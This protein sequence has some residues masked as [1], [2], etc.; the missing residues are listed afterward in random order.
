MRKFAL[1]LLALLSFVFLTCGSGNY[2]S[3][4][5]VYG[6]EDTEYILYNYHPELYRYYSA[7]VLRVNSIRQVVRY[8]GTVDYRVNYD[9]VRYYY[10]DAE[11]INAVMTYLPD[12]YVKY[13]NGQI[14][15]NYVWRYVESGNICHAASYRYYFN[16]YY[17]VYYPRVHKYYYMMPLPPPRHIGPVHHHNHNHYSPGYNH[18]PG[19]PKPGGMGPGGNHHNDHRP[20]GPG[21]HGGG[22]KPGG[23]NGSVRPGPG[24]G[25]GGGYNPPRSSGGS[26]GSRVGGTSPAHHGSPSTARP[27]TSSPSR[28]S[29]YGGGYRSGQPTHHS[30]PSSSPSRSSYGGSSHSGSHGRSQSRAGGRR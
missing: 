4:A 10:S 18:H 11:K 14:M 9:Y 7:G 22:P 16:S 6:D 13:I 30:S 29:S 2:V 28:G 5:Q 23:N 3:Q 15:I 19:G 21:T 27:S 20:N 25:N 12:L 24:S 1:M 26:Q 17:S 8:D